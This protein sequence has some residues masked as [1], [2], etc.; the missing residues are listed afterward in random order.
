MSGEMTQFVL[1]DASLNIHGVNDHL[2]DQQFCE[3]LALSAADAEAHP[4]LRGCSECAAELSTMRRSLGMFRD[5]SRAYADDELRRLPQIA[6]PSRGMMILPAMR[7]AWWLTAAA[8]MF[9][10]LAPMQMQRTRVSHD[11]AAMTVGVATVS[12]TQSDEALL[13]DVDREASAS[14][15]SSMQALANPSTSIDVPTSAATQRKD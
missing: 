3:L 5:A 9:A 13:E 14:L 7:P 12:D 10:A 4:H 6:L 15:P 11:S 2:S 8:L 1:E